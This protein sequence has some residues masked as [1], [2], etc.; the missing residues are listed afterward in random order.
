MSHAPSAAPIAAPRLAPGRRFSLSMMMFLEYA[1]WGAWFVVLNIYLEK[2]LGFSG[3]QVG[4][5]YGTMALGTI[6]APLFVGQIADRYFSSEKLMGWL[7][8]AG[9]VLLVAW[10][11]C[12]KLNLPIAVFGLEVTTFHVMYV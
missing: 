6:F 1:I 11:E 12:A 7:H 3:T 9:A 5:I 2:N 8:L 10:A 4:S